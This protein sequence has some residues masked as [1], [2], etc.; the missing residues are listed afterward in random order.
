LRWWQ[1]ASWVDGGRVRT[2]EAMGTEWTA[3][4][5][6]LALES[7]DARA[8]YSGAAGDLPPINRSNLCIATNHPAPTEGLVC[9][10]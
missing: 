1:E 9:T 4:R 2:Q 8:R 10:L 6:G 3:R 7:G 5:V